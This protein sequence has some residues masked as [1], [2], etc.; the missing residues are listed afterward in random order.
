MSVRMRH[1][2]IEDE[3]EVPEISVPVYERSGWVVVTGKKT[4]SAATSRQTQGES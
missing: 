2:G 3:I 4:S 1:D